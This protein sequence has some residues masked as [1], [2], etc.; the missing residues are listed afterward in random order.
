MENCSPSRIEW[1]INWSAKGYGPGDFVGVCVERNVGAI[2]A[3]LA[4]LKVGAA[5][6]PLDPEYPSDRLRYMVEDSGAKLVIAH[7][8]LAALTDTLGAPVFSL[9]QSDPLAPPV[10]AA[11]IDPQVQ[12]AYLIYTSG[13]TGKPKGVCVPH[14]AVVNFLYAMRDQPGMTEDD[15]T[16]AMTTLS[17]D[18]SVLEIYLPLITG[19]KL[20]LVSRDVAR[21]GRR[22]IE[23][24]ERHGVTVMQAT[25]STWR[26][27]LEAGWNGGD[28]RFKVLSGGEPLP[29]DLVRPL[30]ERSSELWN[31]YG[32]TETTVWSTAF[33]VVDPEATI[34]VGAPINNTSL[35]IVDA[36]DNA[37]GANV[38][39]E[40]LIGGDGV[41]L[42]YHQRPELTAERFVMIEN[43]RYYRTG[44]LARF[45]PDGQVECLG[46]IDTQVKLHGHRI[47]LGEIEAVLAAHSDVRRAAATL[48]EDRPGDCRLVGYVVPHDNG[49]DRGTLL[50]FVAKSLPDYM[51]PHL[52]VEVPELT[53]T[54][55]GKLDRAA[56]PQPSAARPALATE[57]VPATTEQEAAC[58]RIWKEVLGLD[59]VGIQDNFF[60]LG[61]NSIL[62]L[63]VVRRMEEELK[64]KRSA[65][66]FFDRPTIQRLLTAPAETNSHLANDVPPTSAFAIVGMAAKFPGAS[67][68]DEFWRHLC[69]G[70]ESLTHFSAEEL[71]P[72]LDSSQTGD[73]NY[74][75]VR[76]IVEDA[77]CFDAAFFGIAPREAELIDPQQR[78]LLELAWATLEDAGC[79]PGQV[80]G[81]IGVWA[82]AY[83]NTYL[84]K[85]LLTNP[86]LVDQVGEF[87]L[88]AY[89]EKDYI[90]SRIAYKLNL[91]GPAVNV[92]TAC[93]TSLVAVIE[94]CNHLALG[95]CDLALAGGVSVCFPQR[96]GHLYQPGSILSPDG[97]CR[98]F[99]KDAAGT[100]F[101]DGAGLVAIK[102]LDDALQAGDQIY[103]VIKGFGL[104]NDGGDKASFTAPSIEGQAEAIGMAHRMADVSADSLDYVEAHGTATPLG[105]PIEV[106]ALQRVFERTTD[107]KQFCLLGSVKSNMG[108]AVAAAGVAGLIKTALAM[109]YEQ[110]P[111]TLHYR[112]PNPQIDFAA[113]PFRVCD[114]RTSWKR[115][116]R[117]R[118]AGVSSFGVG[119]TNAHV[120]LEEAPAPATEETLQPFPAQVVLLSAKSEAALQ[121][122]TQQ[123]ADHL[124]QH[125]ALPLADVA[126][127]LQL[128]RAEFPYRASVAVRDSLE[129]ISMLRDQP[130]GK[131][132]CG[133]HVGGPR[134]IVFMFPGQGAQ[135]LGMGRDLYQHASVFREALEAC[136]QHLR[137]HLS[138]GLLEALFAADSEAAQQRLQ[139]TALTQPAMFALSYANAR[140]W[141]S[142]G[143]RPVALIG[144]SIGEFV[145]ACL[146][147]VMSLPDATRL[148]AE[149]GRLMSELPRGSML[150][151]RAPAEAVESHLNGDLVI[152]SYNSPKLC[153]VAGPTDQ[154]AE[155]ET[156]LT[157]A[158]VAAK[159][160]F[161]SHAFH[162]PMMDSI[163]E[164]FRQRLSEVALHPPQIPIVSTVTGA[165]LTDAE[166]TD[167][168]Y[169]ADHLKLPVRFADAVAT[170][171]EAQ[172]EAILLELGPRKTLTSLAKQVAGKKSTQVALPTLGDTADNHVEW[173]STMHAVGSLWS[174]GAKF[175]W[176]AMHPQ[177]VQKRSLPTYPF[178]RIPYFV[179]P[180]HSARTDAPTGEHADPK[181]L[182]NPQHQESEPVPSR[183]TQ[184]MAAIHQ[185][186]ET[187]SGYDLTDG[188]ADATFFEM[189]MDSL[190]LTQTAAA[191]K[192]EFGVE[193]GFRQLL[194]ELP[195]VAALCEFLDQRLP[196]D[197]FPCPAA[198]ATEA[199]PTASPSIENPAV[200]VPTPAAAPVAN[201]CP[202]D[203]TSIIRAQLHLMQQQL[204]VLSG[205]PLSLAEPANAPADVSSPNVTRAEDA[206]VVSAP[207]PEPDGKKFGA[208][209]R[210]NLTRGQLSDAMSE[211]L[212][213][214]VGRYASRM[215]QS[216]AYAQ[217]HRRYFADPRTVSGFRPELKE[218]TFPVVAARS[219]GGYLWDLDGNQYIDVTSGFGSN[220]LGHSPEFM[221]EAITE[222]LQQGYE[223]GPQ[224]PAAGEAAALFCEL[225]GAERVAFCNTG[226]E[227]VL[228][229]LRL[230]RARTGRD[231][232]VMFTGDY[233]GILDEVVVRG[234]KQGKS[235]P[236]ATGIPAS[237]VQNA[238]ILEYGTDATLKTI[239]A[240]LDEYAA[241]LVEP[242]QSRRPGFQPEAFLQALGRLTAESDTALIF[243]EVIT[244]FRIGPGG[245]Q[246]H[247][248]VQADLATYGKVVGGG[249]PI[250]AI[251]GRAEYMDGLD[252]GYWAFG[253]D[254]QPEVG[255]TYF[256]G[257]FV[258]HPLAMAASRAILSYIKTEG[259]AIYDRL[260]QLTQ[261]MA[262][263]LNQ[264]FREWEAP[265]HLAHFGSLFKVQFEQ[266]LPWGELLFAA[267]RYRGIH[268]WDHRPCLLTLAHT[269][270]DV[271]A[272]VA[273]F[274]ESLA[275]LQQ[276]GFLPGSPSAGDLQPL[277]PAPGARLGRDREGR[278][279]WFVED[280]DN[281][282]KY[283][284]VAG[285]VS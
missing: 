31:L 26:F 116:D 142:F 232:F 223:I 182:E 242:V 209:A 73:P 99:D 157:Q 84:T 172:P 104:N 105:D 45:T 3:L 180:G 263:E 266:E 275:E 55:N 148:I 210:V 158:H 65:A 234:N 110:I 82:G 140:L 150:S 61:G 98:P 127:T 186:F 247:F 130:R 250:G 18:I 229:A 258:R 63:Q 278:P 122:Q 176:R 141:Q 39:G 108:H 34:L 27:I 77:V 17:F 271:D 47:E 131:F 124:E 119:G 103:A 277:N 168:R 262:D 255:M 282:G 146:A 213:C 149:R 53:Y 113:S 163:V 132:I 227:A 41:A 164:P 221:V 181:P 100:L 30:L 203:A 107:K 235:F 96:S 11:A 251:A 90:A 183:K 36:G 169:W 153:V 214:W 159:R 115:G 117:P 233:H 273:A 118:R 243:D 174:A 202:S 133:K 40:L 87:Q 121:Q 89:N 50:Q 114:Q 66:E 264:L 156:H 5:Y 217:R 162:S 259:Q 272:I 254:S 226:S 253:D 267:L 97:H 239:E 225:T 154:I 219:Q 184:I 92:N 173:Q 279:A 237:N 204:Q 4:V 12:P 280:T 56:L 32:P 14:A 249:M 91:R 276:A 38:E 143:V 46:R 207:T 72:A 145:A 64:V 178:A 15:V 206:V 248:G 33:Q 188:D 231:K 86:E 123:L 160:L 54:P 241:I 238:V 112:Q 170:Q 252:G 138:V 245:A 37:V 228:G 189:G 69:D 198:V 102:R 75:S 265:L 246:Q 144:H 151:V 6:V 269:A 19:S 74:V 208:A 109:H 240:H 285:P 129:A 270:A 83:Q 167:P 57:F 51:V 20:V 236:A 76:G 42:G 23:A 9:D 125:P 284:Q 191:M 222:Q 101:G 281:P 68:V 260:N 29:P 128:G 187:T 220:F 135:Y 216:K 88:S 136:D 155:L 171:W 67:N 165:R 35:L 8:T 256:A 106:A 71:D 93:S 70:T 257:T 2:A 196:A 211:S 200:A 166:A 283:L 126:A 268:I 111:Q 152:A 81:S 94:A 28:G 193:V 147:G 79:V 177:V 161:T 58:V 134:S 215:P 13:S 194:E 244:G 49:V 199:A 212:A 60:E 224:T 190:V 10:P 139:D 21:D 230:A 62:A 78:L 22:L 80:D 48:R 205:E 175:D 195:T 24:V 1:R 192:R 43:Q 59:L 218:M 197:H 44:D 179:A 261:R 185:V 85:N 16:L 137:P 201:E 7:S 274:R 52:L 95:R 120:V 25:P